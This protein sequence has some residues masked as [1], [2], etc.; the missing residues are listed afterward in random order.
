MSTINGNYI[1]LID[2]DASFR[3]SLEQAL[4]MLGYHVKSY[5]SA[6]SFLG[7]EDISWPALIISDMRMPGRSGVELQKRIIEE[8]LGI[9][10]LFISGESSLDEAVTSMRQG[11]V[12]FLQKPFNMEALLKVVEAA[13]EQQRIN[14]VKSHKTIIRE[15][16]LTR[17]APREREVCDLMAKGYTNP[18][19]AVEL[20]LS[21]ETVKQY[22]KNIYN[23]LAIEDLAEL[24]ALMRY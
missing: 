9:P 3:D 12:D 18:K 11:A 19:I 6:E 10:M 1:Y 17:L 24:I 15:Q 2:D 21:I 8:N 20:E 22:K 5:S 7:I 16:K 13:F 14:L 4:R 23:K